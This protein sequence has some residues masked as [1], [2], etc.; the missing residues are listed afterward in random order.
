MINNHFCLNSNDNLQVRCYKNLHKNKISVQVKISGNWKVVYHAKSVDLI[1]V[2]FKVSQSGREKVLRE[3]KKN[4]HAFVC[5]KLVAL[6]KGKRIQGEKVLYNP[7]KTKT[8]V[9]AGSGDPVASA[10]VARVD[11]ESGIEVV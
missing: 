7:Y 2:T 11:V 4:V 1:N 8:F 9:L 5:G 10:T 3:K 6:D